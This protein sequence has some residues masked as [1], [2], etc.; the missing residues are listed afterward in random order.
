M[1]IIR[2][3]RGITGTLCLKKFKGEDTCLL[4]M[5][6]RRVLERVKDSEEQHSNRRVLRDAAVGTNFNSFPDEPVVKPQEEVSL[7]RSSRAALINFVVMFLAIILSVIQYQESPWLVIALLVAVLDQFADAYRV[8][9]GKDPYPRAIL[10]LKLDIIVDY[11]QIP[12]GLLVVL[13]GPIYS[14]RLSSSYLLLFILV[15]MG[16]L[17]TSWV[18]VASLHSKRRRV[19]R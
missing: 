15:G 13:L 3:G 2:D 17:L 10:R 19:L 18:E 7:S 14:S 4:G 16:L 12:L 5:R 11:Y 1:I 9:I 6:R 8:A